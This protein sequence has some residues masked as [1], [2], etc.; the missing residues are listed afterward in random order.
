MKKGIILLSGLFLVTGTLL[1]LSLYQDNNEAAFWKRIDQTIDKGAEWLKKQQQND[2][3]WAGADHPVYG[4]GGK[5]PLTY[6]RGYTALALLAL[7]VSDV[8][9]SDPVIR[10]GFDFLYKFTGSTNLDVLTNYDGG[11]ILMALEGKYWVQEKKKQQAIKDPKKRKPE[12]EWRYSPTAEDKNLMSTMAQGLLDSQS[13]AGGWRYYKKN[14]RGMTYLGDDEDVSATQFALLG[15][16][17]ARRMGYNVPP[18]VFKNAIKFLLSAQEKDGP[19]VEKPGPK[20]DSRE[21]YAPMEGDRARGWPYA[22]KSGGGDPKETEASG[23]MTC[24]G[25]AGLLLCK[26]ELT[27]S[28]SGDELKKCDQAIFD[29]LAWLSHNWNIK[30]NPNGYRSYYYYLYGIERVGILGKFEKFV[31]KSW[32]KLGAN[33]LCDLQSGDGWW[34]DKGEVGTPK[35]AGTIFALLF[36][37]RGTVPIGDVITP[38]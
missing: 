25:I 37:K 3:G 7:L 18:A 27:K 20:P 17:S 14:P 29:G 11:A 36:L 22:I 19:K 32:Y 10:K 6:R 15:L 12:E 24:A 34:E 4:G 30:R 38:R 2:G 8:N 28:L 9:P 1:S 5:S 33:H 16:K 35:I 26:S 23:G 21:T 31:D 13:P